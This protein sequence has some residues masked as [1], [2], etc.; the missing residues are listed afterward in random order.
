MTDAP[1]RRRTYARPYDR[2]AALQAALDLFW[3]K[4]YHATSLKDL[5]AALN[6]KP[7]SIYAAFTSKE[8]LFLAALERYFETNQKALRARIATAPGPVAGL[9]GYL[10]DLGR[11]GG[12]AVPCHACMLVKTLLDAT[13]ADPTIAAA[14]RRYLDLMH[15]DIAAAFEQA[16]TAGDIAA[17][18]DPELLASRYQSDVT[19]LRI[20][21]HRGMAPTALA[22]LAE[23]MIADLLRACGERQTA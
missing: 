3:A 6:M 11:A 15:A 1:A 17:D 9:V 18:A 19:A 22:A 12:R 5:E 16:R 20:E 14:A 8:A 2:D 23:S 10:R 13:P 21:A 7:G 4:G